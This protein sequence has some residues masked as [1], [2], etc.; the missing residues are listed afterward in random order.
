MHYGAHAA[1]HKEGQD[2]VSLYMIARYE[3][4]DSKQTSLPTSEET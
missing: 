2:H 1:Y 4:E 3:V